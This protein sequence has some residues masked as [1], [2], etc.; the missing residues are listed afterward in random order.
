MATLFFADEIMEKLLFYIYP[1]FNKEIIQPKIFFK[2]KTDKISTKITKFL[3]WR[4][5]PYV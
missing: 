2:T 1:N 4:G 3:E 5:K